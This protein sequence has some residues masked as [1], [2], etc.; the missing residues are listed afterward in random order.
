MRRE[1]TGDAALEGVDRSGLRERLHEA[2]V[3]QRSCG[4]SPSRLASEERFPPA[5]A[6]RALGKGLRRAIDDDRSLPRTHEAKL[7]ARDA[8]EV[9]VGCEVFAQTLQLGLLATELIDLVDK[10]AALRV[11]AIGLRSSLGGG[12]EEEREQQHG[13][14]QHDVRRPKSR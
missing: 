11:E 4:A 5:L 3:A 6:R 2:S 8:L 7:G 10:D 13:D 14:R 1:C 12:V 9:F